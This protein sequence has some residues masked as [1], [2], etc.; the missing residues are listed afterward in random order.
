[1][2][3]ER[4]RKVA[5]TIVKAGFLPLPINDT[6]IE[7]LIRNSRVE[8]IIEKEEYNLYIDVEQVFK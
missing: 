2:S 3:E 1:M 6:M 5:R 7:S 4:Y 8:F